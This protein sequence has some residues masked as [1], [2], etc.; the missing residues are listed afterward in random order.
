MHQSEEYFD[1]YMIIQGNGLLKPCPILSL[2]DRIEGVFFSRVT[3]D[4]FIMEHSD[5]TATDWRKL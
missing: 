3:H 1:S 4:M 5:K 2:G